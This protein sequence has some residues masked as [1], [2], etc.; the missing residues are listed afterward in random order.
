MCPK[1]LFD[2]VKSIN[3]QQRKAVREMRL[4]SLLIMTSNGI[5]GKLSRYVLNCFDLDKMKINLPVGSIDI[6]SDLIHNLLGIPTGG[7]KINEFD[8]NEKTKTGLLEWRNIYN[9]KI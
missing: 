3:K 9:G 2:V 4:G 1:M 5:P 8:L 6:T 7:R